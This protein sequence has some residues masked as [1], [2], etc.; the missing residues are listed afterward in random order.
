MLLSQELGFLRQEVGVEAGVHPESLG[1]AP[2]GA[3]RV[4]VVKELH[5]GG[6]EREVVRPQRD[7]PHV[8]GDAEQSDREEHTQE[9]KPAQ[10]Q[11]ALQITIR[12]M[13]CQV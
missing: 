2:D 1:L 13:G 12:I 10:P 6:G 7:K 9:T 8:Q 11:G 5:V 3:H 4:L